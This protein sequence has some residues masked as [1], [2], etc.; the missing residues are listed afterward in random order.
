MWPP[1][2]FKGDRIHVQQLGF[3]RFVRACFDGRSQQ[4]NCVVRTLHTEIRFRQTL[5]GLFR[6][7]AVI[8]LM[9]TA[10]RKRPCVQGL[11]F[12]VLALKTMEIGKSFNKGTDLKSCTSVPLLGPL[13][14][15]FSKALG[16]S[17][18]IYADVS[19]N[20]K[21]RVKPVGR[22]FRLA[23]IKRLVRRTPVRFVEYLFRLGRPT[24]LQ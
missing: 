21:W 14:P 23:E 16:L 5:I 24:L 10:Y 22:D 20:Q 1:T 12:G 17:V 7:Q 13:Y 18:V 6:E 15:I 11:R 19:S 8:E 2:I 4:L 9:K 3:S